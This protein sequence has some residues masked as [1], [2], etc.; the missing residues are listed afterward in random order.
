[1]IPEQLKQMFGLNSQKDMN[2]ANN[3][4]KMLDQMAESSPE[5]YK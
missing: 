4:W 2:M 3:I 5:K 1:M